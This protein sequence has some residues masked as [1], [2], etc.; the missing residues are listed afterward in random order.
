MA[1]T[2]RYTTALIA[3]VTVTVLWTGCGAGPTSLGPLLDGLSA[4]N[5]ADVAEVEADG[6]LEPANTA[7]VENGGVTTSRGL[8]HNI[9]CDCESCRKARGL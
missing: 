2:T 8:L 3:L 7:G 5:W 6:P 1:T 4:W 9:Q